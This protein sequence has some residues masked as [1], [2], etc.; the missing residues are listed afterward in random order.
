MC[1]VAIIF[2]QLSIRA[3]ISISLYLAR[4]QTLSQWLYA[5]SRRLFRVGDWMARDLARY[6]IKYTLVNSTVWFDLAL[7][8]L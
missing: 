1:S 6:E 2:S 7:G 8:I 3:R 4:R 5:L